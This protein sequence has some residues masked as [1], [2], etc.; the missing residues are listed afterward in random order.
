MRGLRAL[1]VPSSS[2]EGLL[3]S[4][5]INKLP[6][7]LRL[8]ISRELS[9]EEWEFE[10]VLRIMEKEVVARERSV[11]AK[12]VKR[13]SDKL[14]STA[15]ALLTGTPGQ[16]SCVYYNH[17]ES[18]PTVKSEG[19]SRQSN[20]IPAFVLMAEHP[21]VTQPVQWKSTQQQH[22]QQRGDSTLPCM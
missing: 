9:E 17:A 3:S 22:T 14:P 1:G 2:Y 5:L 7:E 21:Q 13:P 16:V 4:V 19:D 10:S 6:T 11:A 18:C 20:T 15:F 12:P 8:I